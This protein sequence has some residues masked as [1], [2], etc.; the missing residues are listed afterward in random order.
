MVILQI[1]VTAGDISLVRMVR[2]QLEF[3]QVV[4]TGTMKDYFV[5]TNLKQ[6][7]DQLSGKFICHIVINAIQ[8]RNIISLTKA[9]IDL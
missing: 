4:F 2:Q 5:P 1:L 9:C 8:G 7:V 3:A 6:N